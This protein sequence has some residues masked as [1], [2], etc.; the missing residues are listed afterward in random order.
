M[1]RIN[2]VPLSP[3]FLNEM[4]KFRAVIS[5]ISFHLFL[6]LKQCAQSKL[7]VYYF[8]HVRFHG[9]IFRR[10]SYCMFTI[11]LLRNFTSFLFTSWKRVAI[12]CID[13]IKTHPQVK[14]LLSLQ[15][16]PGTTASVMSSPFSNGETSTM[17]FHSW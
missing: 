15:L 13:E 3:G 1:N 5:P 16:F 9:I 14:S 12:F 6:C 8:P 7:S 2:F 10:F 17:C 11:V 4:F